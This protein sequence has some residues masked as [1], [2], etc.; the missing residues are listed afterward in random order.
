MDHTTPQAPAAWRERLRGY[1]WT[2]AVEGC[3]EASV[4][5]L[6]APGRPS[7]FLKTES[8]GP[9]AELED[10]AERLR[11]LAAQ[12]IPCAPLL[13]F[14]R[15]AGQDWMLLGAV[16]GRNLED[17]G[18]DPAT[19]VRLVAEALRRLHALDPATCPFDHRAAT[20]IDRA[21]ARL[22]AGVVIEADL[23]DEH[24]H[25]APSDLFAR[26]RAQAPAHEELVV[27]HGDACLPNLI[28]K[29]GQGM[30][31][32]S[33]WIDCGRLGVADRWQDLALATRDIGEH[34][35]QQWVK[36]FLQAYGVAHDAQRAAFYRL[37]DE[38]F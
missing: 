8:S 3:S 24:R 2:P 23:D 27:T 10:E 11:W 26:L 32:I 16:P 31:E 29:D 37:L 36:P 6:D 20:R 1:R 33:G 9:L 21:Y 5:R 18:L 13:G 35:G 25:L 28:V 38:F 30:G 34:L 4:Y 22:Q 12:G 17:A 15:E 7:L 19:T 14:A